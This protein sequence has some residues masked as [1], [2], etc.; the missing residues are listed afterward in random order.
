MKRARGSSSIEVNS[1]RTRV[2]SHRQ[3]GKILEVPFD[4][5]SSLHRSEIRNL[6]EFVERYYNFKN[7]YL[8]LVLFDYRGKCPL[9]KTVYPEREVFP[10]SSILVSII[11]SS[12]LLSDITIVL[13]M[14]GDNRNVHLTC[15]ESKSESVSRYTVCPFVL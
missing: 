7:F 5:T 1:S 15:Q 11:S 13:T 14:T 4:S 3:L 8:Y 12:V 9:Q 2:T 6:V 10:L